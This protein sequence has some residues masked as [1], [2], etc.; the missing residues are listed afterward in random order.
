MLLAM[1]LHCGKYLS[2]YPGR[3][4]GRGGL[5]EGPCWPW[6]IVEMS[7]I[8]AGTDARQKQ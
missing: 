5:S 4:E 3:I 6:E 7:E 2:R 8:R 1:W